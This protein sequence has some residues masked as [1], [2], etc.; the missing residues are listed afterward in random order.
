MSI[1]NALHTALYSRLSS[2]TALTALLAGTAAVYYEQAPDDASLPYVVFSVQSGGDENMA[3]GHRMK[4]VAYF[5]RGYTQAGPAA[6]GTIDAQI[7][8]RLHQYPL[9]I[10]GWSTLWA[11]RE[12]DLATVEIDAAQVKTWMAGGVYR[13]R[14]DLQ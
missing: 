5:I 13:F 8:A 9:S 7:D 3:S 1:Y 10:T 4:N 14:A 6:A 12:Q 11:A 2:G